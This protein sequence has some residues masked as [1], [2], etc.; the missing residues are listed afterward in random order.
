VLSLTEPEQRFVFVNVS[1]HP[2]P[3]LL[4]GF[5]APVVLKHDYSD[6]QLAHLM[7]HDA[8]AFNRWEAGQRLATRILLRAIEGASGSAPLDVPEH[9]IAA[10]ARVLADAG[11]DPAFAG[12]ALALPSEAYL[13]EQIGRADPEVL[14]ASRL[15]LRRHIAASLRE[16]LLHT[17]HAQATVGPYSPDARSAGKRTLRNTCLAYLL[18]LD[19][20]E[21]RA[22][23]MHQFDTADNMTDAIAA[24]STLANTDCPERVAALDRFYAKWREEPLVVDKWLA[25]QATSRLPTTLAEVERLTRHE[26]F[27]LR[28]PNKVYA[29]IR[30]F[31][32]NYL[33]FNGADGAG[34]AFLADQIIAL[35][36]LNPQVAARLAR[37]FDRWRKFDDARQA[38]AR[39]ALEQVR[40]TD[41]LSKDVLEVVTKALS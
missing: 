24:L 40:D 27:D 15:A 1:A 39:R 2:V 22:L 7:A 11:R 12:E 6:A 26:A 28:N 41:G 35:D 14:H 36:P 10:V 13:A 18:E 37:G 34:Y 5:S 32:A 4:R 21:M 38:H 16:A 31:A 9:F 19:E 29:L 17:Y 23:A 20:P 33:R 8:D 30:G 3:S 25:V